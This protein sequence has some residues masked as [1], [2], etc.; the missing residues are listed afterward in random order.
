MI[1][2]MAFNSPSVP[3]RKACAQAYSR[4]STKIVFGRK[5][6]VQGTQGRVLMPCAGACEPRLKQGL[7][8][9]WG[10]REKQIRGAY[11]EGPV[12]TLSQI[13]AK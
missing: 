2:L 13:R 8:E 5:K 1:T 11:Q 7:K 12:L 9:E 3:S 6:L 10:Q 4:N